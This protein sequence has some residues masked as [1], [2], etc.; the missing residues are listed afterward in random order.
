MASTAETPVRRAGL[1]KA[2]SVLEPVVLVALPLFMAACAYFK[3]PNSALLTAVAAGLT[4]VPFFAHFELSHL[5]ARDLMP[6]VVMSA[7]GVAGRMIFAPVPAI[8]PIMAIVVITGLSFGRQTGFITG[9]LIALVSNIFFG[10]GPWT[11][12]Q[13]YGFGMGGYIAGC[14]RHLPAFKNRFAVAAL[15]FGLVFLYGFIL[16]TWTLVGFV[17]PMTPASVASTYTVGFF[18]NLMHATG[19]VVFL[20][21]IATSWPKMFERI[22][23]KYGIDQGGAA[24]SA[25]VPSRTNTPSAPGT[26]QAPGSPGLA[27]GASLLGKG[28]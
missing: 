26:P 27:A 3:V 2:L 16:D 22:K 14:V 11:P 19:T 9:A 1:L 18:Y 17:D 13:M 7:L 24:E 8:K 5:R 15:G 28:A 12:W 25:I 4:L 23:V 21:P 6:I 20:L 10:Q